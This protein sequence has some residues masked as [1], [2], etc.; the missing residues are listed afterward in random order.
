MAKKSKKQRKQEYDAKYSS[1]PNEINQRIISM[2]EKLNVKEEDMG[3]I[4]RRK[5]EIVTNT[6]YE[7]LKLVIYEM[8]EG[9]KR[10]RFNGNSFSFYVEDAAVNKKLMT[11][12]MNNDMPDFKLITTPVYIDL[13]YFLP[14]PKA[15][16]K[17]D[18]ILAEMGYIECIEKPDF[19]NCAKTYTDA[20]SGCIYI[21]D[22]YIV[23]ARVRKFFSSKPRVELE[24][25]WTNGYASRF[26]QKKVIKSKLYQ[27][28]NDKGQAMYPEVI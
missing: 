24:I 27:D 23:D 5:E 22:K 19:D 21:D 3:R 17:D 15:M 8:P 13:V 18:Q 16:P 6:K 20:S 9:S 25:K 12:L 7:K 14:I 28:Y 26:N 1:I 4:L 2:M 11:T 10:P